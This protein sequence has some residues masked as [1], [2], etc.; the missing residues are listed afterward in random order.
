LAPLIAIVLIGFS[1]PVSTSGALGPYFWFIAGV[2]AYW[3]T[4]LRRER[5]DAQPARPARPAPL[6]VG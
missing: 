2:E 6:G 5:A 1:G 4:G 3:L